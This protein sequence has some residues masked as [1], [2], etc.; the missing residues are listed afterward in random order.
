MSEPIE[1]AVAVAAK[2]VPTYLLALGGF[3]LMPEG[4]WYREY[5]AALCLVLAA[6]WLKAWE[7]DLD[8]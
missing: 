6:L 8:D 2:W 4:P 5:A 7:V 1:R 3:M